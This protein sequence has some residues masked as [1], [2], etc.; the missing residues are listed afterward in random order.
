MASGYVDI[1]G[2][3]LY[4]EEAGEGEALVLVH[5]GFVDSGMWDAQWEAF[6]QRYRVIRFDMRGYGKSDTVKAPVS[7]RDD[8]YRL[9]KHLK[10][11]R[12]HLLGCSMGGE[13]VLDLALEHPELA[14]SLVL[15]SAVPSGFEMQGPPPP[16]VLEMMEAAQSG[17]T[18]KTS[19]LQIRIWVDGPSRQPEQVD[20]AVRQRAAEM[21]RIPVE[22]G[23]WAKADMQ[24]LN[25]LDPPA[26]GR[27]SEVNVPT[28][29]IAGAFDDPEILRAADVLAAE[30]PNAQQVIIPDGAHVPNMEQPELFNRAVL[31]F[32]TGV[33]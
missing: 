2:E 27:L 17:D 13:Q 29:V 8:L 12:A 16:L 11:E 18:A 25:P 4:Y 32:L 10:V 21:N 33:G 26:V 5:A 31:D 24:P 20:A 30:I 28:L 22:R 6:A 3:K 9:L 15:V 19:E 1:N 14:K 7:R 23:T